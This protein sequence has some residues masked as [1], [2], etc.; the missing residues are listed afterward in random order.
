MDRSSTTASSVA[1][2]MS[3]PWP[4]RRPPRPPRRPPPRAPA[5]SRRQLGAPLPQLVDYLGWRG[6]ARLADDDSLMQRELSGTFRCC[7][8]QS[9]SAGFRSAGCS[10]VVGTTLVLVLVVA[11]TASTPP[12]GTSLLRRPPRPAVGGHGRSGHH[13][14]HRAGVHRGH[15]R[16]V[17][18][19]HR[20]PRQ[21]VTVALAAALQESKLHNLDYGDRDSVGIF[22][23]R[24]SEGWG[25]A[26]RL[27]EPR[28][29]HDQVLRRPHPGTRVRHHARLR[30]ARRAAQHG[31]LC[32][33][34]VGEPG[35][36]AGRVLHRAVA[37]R[38]VLLVQ[39]VRPGEPDGG[40][41]ADGA[42][43]GRWGRKR[44]WPGS[45]RSVRARKTR[46][47]PRSCT[48]SGPRPGP[49]PTGWSRTRRPTA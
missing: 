8:A 33:R 32:L 24:P 13:A 15:H 44:L 21:A 47:A 30:A 34:A 40:G 27:E 35:R 14:R 19:R 6:Q 46:E 49:W 28:L 12:S 36:P 23:Q 5:V 42:T 22:Q 29:R 9:R 39:P 18:A 7:A 31:R 11:A 45:P 43:S 38:G 41:A 48:S 16:G 26:I 37:A 2:S 1:G 10:A 25:P 3:P 17:A 20:L 4:R